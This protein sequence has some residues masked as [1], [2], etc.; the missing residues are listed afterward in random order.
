MDVL[1]ILVFRKNYHVQADEIDR[2]TYNVIYSRR[3][4]ALCKSTLF[5]CTLLARLFSTGTK[6]RTLKE[7]CE[8]ILKKRKVDGYMIMPWIPN[9]G[10]QLGNTGMN[11]KSGGQYL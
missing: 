5:H 2:P 9:P 7:L 11:Q 6:I 4:R 10:K 3:I 1:C 8:D